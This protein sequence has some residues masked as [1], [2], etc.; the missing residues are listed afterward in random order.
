MCANCP[1]SHMTLFLGV[2]TALR[3]EIPDF[4]KLRLR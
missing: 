2:E 4:E 1:S 3:R